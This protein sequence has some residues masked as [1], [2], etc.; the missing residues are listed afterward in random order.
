MRK[1]LLDKK[2][3][4]LAPA[5]FNYEKALVQKLKDMGSQVTFYDERPSNS[6][7]VKAMIRLNKKGSKIIIDKYYRRILREIKGLYFDYMIFFQAEATPR[8]FLERLFKDAK[9]RKILY[10]WD[11]V[12]DK[13]DNISDKDLFDDVFTFDPYDSKY[14]GLKFRP[15]FFTD[16][17]LINS[18]P[19]KQDYQFDFSFI[20]TVRKDRYEIVQALKE[21]NKKNFVFYY[22][23]SKWIFF[24]FKYIKKDMKHANIYDFSFEPLSHSTIQDVL[25]K[26]CVIVDIQKPYQVGLTIRTIELLASKKKFVTTNTEILKYN[27]YEP[28]N[29]ALLSREKPTIHEDFVNQPMTEISKNILN[30]YSIGYFLMELLG[31]VNS[32]DYYNY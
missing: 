25:K 7:F 6:T 19:E 22:L 23:Q 14:Y 31:L 29:I 1:A 3:L 11:S 15:L 16:N 17:Y 2:I 20:G 13:P 24:Y 4:V 12:A 9:C 30:Q 8:W 5:F 21:Q 26:T 32:G 10:L 28:Q 18:Y 27:F